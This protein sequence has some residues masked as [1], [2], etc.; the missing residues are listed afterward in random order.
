MCV[1]G[2]G[3]WFASFDSQF[4]RGAEDERGGNGMVFFFGG[5]GLFHLR[6]CLFPQYPKEMKPCRVLTLTDNLDLSI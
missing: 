3:G 2:G 5:G 6:V 4:L 1:K